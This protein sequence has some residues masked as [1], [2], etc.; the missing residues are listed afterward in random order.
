[1]GDPDFF[2]SRSQREHGR[3]GLLGRIP[4]SSFDTNAPIERINANYSCAQYKAQ[5]SFSPK[6]AATPYRRRGEATTPFVPRFARSTIRC[7]SAPPS[8]KPKN[9]PKPDRIMEKVKLMFSQREAITSRSVARVMRNFDDGDGRI[10]KQELAKGVKMYL[11]TELTN[12]ELDRVFG[13]FDDNGSGSITID[14]IVA[15]LAPKSFAQLLAT[16]SDAQPQAQGYLSEVYTPNENEA[17]QHEAR[18]SWVQPAQSPYTPQSVPNTAATRALSQ[19]IEKPTKYFRGVAPARARQ[20]AG[21]SV[22][23]FG[24]GGYGHDV[25]PSI[26]T[27]TAA[28]PA[29]W[30][31][32]ALPIAKESADQNRNHPDAGAIYDSYAEKLAMKHAALSTQLATA[33]R[34]L[35]QVGHYS[36]R[37]GHDTSFY[38]THRPNYDMLLN[39][40][41]QL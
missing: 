13:Y 19:T 37:P 29:S 3:P 33:S 35:F 1:M 8:I 21:H 17:S 25:A 20:S 39:T 22:D 5:H 27:M 18:D 15:E 26:N 12:K 32:R 31:A 30:A 10:T 9:E 6:V 38:S 24:R 7:Q 14:E 40:S 23:K 2:G 28:V 11:N 36:S 4:G 41:T 34:S 16:G